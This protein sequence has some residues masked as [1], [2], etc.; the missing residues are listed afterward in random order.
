MTKLRK[1]ALASIAGLAVVK[2]ADATMR[3]KVDLRVF[4]IHRTLAARADRFGQARQRGVVA[5]F[6]TALHIGELL[7]KLLL[8]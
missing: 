4:Q 1:S 7:G 2:Q 8:F 5:Q 3:A 6:F